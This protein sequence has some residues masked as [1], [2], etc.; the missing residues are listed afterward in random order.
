MF[1]LFLFQKRNK[2]S[3][4]LHEYFLDGASGEDAENDAGGVPARVVGVNE[5]KKKKQVGRGRESFFFPVFPPSPLLS[6]FVGG[7]QPLTSK[8]KTKSMREK[9]VKPKKK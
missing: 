2:Q 8:K 3:T 5:R 4:H 7:R 9:K 6:C 1:P